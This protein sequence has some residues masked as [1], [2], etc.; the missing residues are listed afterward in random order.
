MVAA[1][2]NVLDRS[3]H[4][5]PGFARDQ[6]LKVRPPGD[7]ADT[8]NPPDAVRATENEDVANGFA[9]AVENA[10]SWTEL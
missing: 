4:W 9:D 7:P 6:F 8:H 3:A 1:A 5:I 10:M 2:H